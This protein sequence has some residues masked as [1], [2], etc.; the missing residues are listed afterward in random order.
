MSQDGVL[1]EKL[2]RPLQVEAY[3][4]VQEL[5][6]YFQSREG[7][8]HSLALHAVLIPLPHSL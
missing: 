8:C 5:R 4:A 1:V 6:E 2:C 3:P 7:D